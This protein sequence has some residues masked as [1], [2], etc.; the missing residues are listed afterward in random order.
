MKEDSYSY[1]VAEV[2]VSEK[3]VYEGMSEDFL[4]SQICTQLKK[5]NTLNKV[6]YL[7]NIDE[8]FIS[9]CISYV[10]EILRNYN[11]TIDRL[12]K[13]KEKNA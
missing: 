9:D 12:Y 10:N 5:E 8:D 3:K 11:E 4:I 6:K 1:Q 13:I 7:M 2:L